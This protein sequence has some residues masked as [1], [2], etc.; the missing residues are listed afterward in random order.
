[1]I[2]FLIA[3]FFRLRSYRSENFRR[4]WMG[5]PPPVALFLA[6]QL[7]V[8][9]PFSFYLSPRFRCVVLCRT[10]DQAWV[11]D[12]ASLVL[13]L[14]YPKGQSG[15]K[16]PW[17][18]FV[19]AFTT[20]FS[21]PRNVN[22]NAL[23]RAARSDSFGS[24]HP[25][26]PLGTRICRVAPSSWCCQPSCESREHQLDSNGLRA[27]SNRRG[28]GEAFPTTATTDELVLH[29][30]LTNVICVF[31][32]GGNPFSKDCK[33]SIYPRCSH[34]FPRRT[35]AY[36]HMHTVAPGNAEEIE[37][38]VLHSTLPLHTTGDTSDAAEGDGGVCVPLSRGRCYVRPLPMVKMTL[39]AFAVD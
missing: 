21:R 20:V 38:E 10:G 28:D 17:W 39:G 30:W 22:G 37:K 24:L 36:R 29:M 11:L 1:M 13:V 25:F 6:I 26:S 34:L 32:F 18:Q 7:Y 4:L 19:R 12:N 33:L 8:E 5:S 9:R 16:R 35:D 3:S 27:Y 2:L 23:L 14:I 15:G 31:S